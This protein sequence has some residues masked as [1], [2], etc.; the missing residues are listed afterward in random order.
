MLNTEKLQILPQSALL[1]KLKQNSDFIGRFCKLK[2]EF[3]SY[4]VETKRNFL[5]NKRFSKITLLLLVWEKLF[6]DES[7]AL[8]TLEITKAAFVSL[9]AK[10][11]LRACFTTGAAPGRSTSPRTPGTGGAHHVNARS[12]RTCVCPGREP[13][14]RHD[15]LPGM[16]HRNGRGGARGLNRRRDPPDGCTGQGLLRP[17]PKSVHGELAPRTSRAGSDKRNNLRLID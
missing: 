14:K 17:F 8:N 12:V 9:F 11:P 5:K 10:N 15:V 7:E 1:A 4:S 13:R 16:R 2:R 3:G 6:S